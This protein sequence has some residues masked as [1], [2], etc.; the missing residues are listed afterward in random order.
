MPYSE[1]EQAILSK[2]GD[3]IRKYRKAKGWSQEELAF[4]ADL[5]RTYIGSME[6]GERNVAVLN[7][8]KIAK[9]LG[10]GVREL[11]EGVG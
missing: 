1:S 6:R 8:V 11:V 10:V 7:L 4:Q 3:N 9:V 2:L 5:D